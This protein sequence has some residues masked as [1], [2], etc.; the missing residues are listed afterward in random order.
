MAFRFEIEAKSL[1]EVR[2]IFDDEYAAHADRPSEGEMVKVLP[3]PSPSLSAKASP[4]Y[5]RATRAHDKKTQPGAF[6]LSVAGLC[7]PVEAIE[8]AL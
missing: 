4:P 2:F 5:R 8:D 1:G 3:S 7:T 6:H